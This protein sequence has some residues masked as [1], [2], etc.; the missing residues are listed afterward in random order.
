M[1]FALLAPLLVGLAASAISIILVGT[2]PRRAREQRRNSP[3]FNRINP[4]NNGRHIYDFFGRRRLGPQPIFGLA[5]DDLDAKEE[6]RLRAAGFQPAIPANPHPAPPNPNILI[7]PVQFPDRT[8]AIHAF[9]ER[10]WTMVRIGFNAINPSPEYLR[11]ADEAAVVLEWTRSIVAPLPP[12]QI[13]PLVVDLFYEFYKL[14]Y[15]SALNWELMGMPH[16]AHENT[17]VQKVLWT[18]AA[19]VCH[20]AAWGIDSFVTSSTCGSLQ[21]W[22]DLRTKDGWV[23]CGSIALNMLD[24]FYDLFPTCFGHHDQNVLHQNMYTRINKWRTCGTQRKAI[25]SRNYSHFDTDVDTSVMGDGMYIGHFNF[26][27]SVLRKF[28]EPWYTFATSRSI[29]ERTLLDRRGEKLHCQ[30]H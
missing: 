27:H 11:M 3:I 15:D 25:W 6:A 16:F 12:R 1:V 18:A 22:I 20:K 28:H 24:I 2:P 10:I 5:A 29:D 8:A 9:G 23:N 4:G 30:A 14:W 7:V 17:K 19:I 21:Q 13:L 26:F